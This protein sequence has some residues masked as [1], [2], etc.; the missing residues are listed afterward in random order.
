MYISRYNNSIIRHSKKKIGIKQNKLVTCIN[1]II[2]TSNCKSNITGTFE[3]SAL[4]AFSNLPIN[5]RKVEPNMSFC[6][7]TLP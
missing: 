5:S 4:D 7:W 2:E 3:D 6:S 1:N